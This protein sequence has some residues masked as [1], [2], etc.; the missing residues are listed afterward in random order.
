MITPTRITSGMIHQDF[1]IFAS[2][3]ALYHSGMAVFGAPN[4]SNEQKTI[5]SLTQ[6]DLGINRRNPGMANKESRV[7]FLNRQPDSG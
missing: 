3:R 6:E 5:H 7:S 1:F 4:Q 2:M